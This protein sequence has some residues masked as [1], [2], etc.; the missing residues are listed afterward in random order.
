MTS[1]MV[2]QCA[3]PPI[4]TVVPQFS[5]ELAGVANVALGKSS[6][7]QGP[8]AAGGWGWGAP[9]GPMRCPHGGLRRPSPAGVGL[10][11]RSQGGECEDMSN[12]VEGLH[13]QPLLA[14]AAGSMAEGTPPPQTCARRHADGEGR[15]VGK[16]VR[17]P[18]VQSLDGD[19]A[20]WYLVVIP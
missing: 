18:E 16:V 3:Q 10:L 2:V 17:T 19:W 7:R 15:R 6:R 14:S 9:G 4:R 5:W 12:T 8:T 1:N 11:R 20:A 13:R